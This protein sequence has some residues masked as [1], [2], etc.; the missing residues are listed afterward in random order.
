[1][2]AVEILG[3]RG[4]ELS[5]INEF[6]SKDSVGVQ[7]GGVQW[8]LVGEDWEPRAEKVSASSC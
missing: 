5:L 2:R 1:M 4:W 3:T 8:E 6:Q 7:H